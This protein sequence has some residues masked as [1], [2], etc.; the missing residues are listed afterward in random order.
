MVDSLGRK[1]LKKSPA[2]SMGSQGLCY[3]LPGF[4]LPC[5][6][7]SIDMGMNGNGGLKLPVSN[8]AEATPYPP[9]SI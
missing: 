7:P 4:R 3:S 8:A 1:L 2:V 6:G 9:N 5:Y